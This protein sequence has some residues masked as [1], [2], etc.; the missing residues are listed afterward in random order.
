VPTQQVTKDRLILV[1][2]KDDRKFFE[3]LLGHLQA[4]HI[5]QVFDYGGKDNL[6]GFLK[7]I[8]IGPDFQV[9]VK[10]MIV[11]DTD[12]NPAGALQSVRSALAAAGLV[13]PTTALTFATGSPDVCIAVLPDAA[14]Q[15][16]LEDLCVASV[17]GD[18]AMHCVQA[19]LQ[20]L[21]NHVAAMPSP[22]AK[23]QAHTFLA[24]RPRP[25]LAVGDAAA[26][27]YWPFGA[28]AFQPLILCVQQ[29]LT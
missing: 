8:V 11:R 23:A 10:L 24:S 17:G 16:A 19:F 2:G 28:T 21:P 20:C 7:Q 29:L 22:I 18:P 14:Q 26:A 25:G 6:R 12:T 3:S 5:A 9:V 13:A 27:G 15:G 1:E 4:I